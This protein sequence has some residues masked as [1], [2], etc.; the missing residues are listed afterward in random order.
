MINMR[1]KYNLSQPHMSM[2]LKGTV[3]TMKG[4]SV[5]TLDTSNNV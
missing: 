2:L 1:T 3:K 4:W 5:K